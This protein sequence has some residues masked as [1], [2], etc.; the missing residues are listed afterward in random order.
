MVKNF[1]FGN[2]HLF[3]KT[4]RNEI[5]FADL[6][7]KV[8]L[9]TGGGQG[10]GLGI[11]MKL[12]GQGAD[13]AIADL[14]HENAVEAAKRVSALGRKAYTAGMDVADKDSVIQAVEKLTEESGGIN[15]LVNNAGVA[16][17]PGSTGTGFRDVDWEFTWQIN[18]KGLSDVTEAV[19][20]QM[21]ARRSGKIINISS[22]AAKAAKYQTA[23][24]ATTK[25]AVVAYTQALAREF[26]LENINVNAVAPGR[27]WTQF[28]QDWMKEREALGDEAVVGQDKY[29]V[30]MG[31]LKEVIPMGRPQTPEDIGALVTFLASDEARNITGQTIQCDGGQVMQ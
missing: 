7:G 15:I 2:Q 5:M 17:A 14:N 24:Y 18:V 25:M 30:F 21:R 1:S 11:V 26:A 8:A 22:V 20:P 31:A 27:I 16:G 9:V 6:S 23:Y 4:E 13:I 19:L 12:A 3:L 29:E 28:H 10:L